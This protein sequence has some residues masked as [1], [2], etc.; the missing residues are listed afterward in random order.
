ML[1]R[2]SFLPL[3]SSGRNLIQSDENVT[4]CYYLVHFP[5]SHCAIGGTAFPWD[6]GGSGGGQLGALRPGFLGGG[7]LMVPVWPRA[8]GMGRELVVSKATRV[9]AAGRGACSL[10]GA[11]ALVLYWTD[12]CSRAWLDV[13]AEGRNKECI[14]FK[15]LRKNCYIKL[16]ILKCFL[17]QI[18]L[19]RQLA[20]L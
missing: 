16:I 20:L 6:G 2:S 1:F 4:V 5:A 7:F 19:L 10:G 8:A 14:Y 12:S 13:L 3:S 18:Y 9:L 15:V 17:W 11:G